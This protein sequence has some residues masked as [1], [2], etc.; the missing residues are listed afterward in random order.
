MKLFLAITLIGF[1]FSANAAPVNFNQRSI[2]PYGLVARWIFNEGSG[3]NAA[4]CSGYENNAWMTN[5]TAG[6]GANAWQ[7]GVIG[8]AINFSNHVPYCFL[9]AGT[10]ASLNLTNSMTISAWVNLRSYGGGSYGRIVDKSAGATIGYGFCVTSL[11]LAYFTDTAS[12]ANFKQGG[13]ALVY[14]QWYHV[15]ITI[16]GTNV[17]MYTNGIQCLSTTVT[18]ATP[19]PNSV[20]YIGDR[21]DLS[22]NFDGVIDDICLYNRPLSA[23]E[24]KQNYGGGYGA[25]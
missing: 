14:N 17:I 2:V 1:C 3:T 19:N 7:A 18:I 20:C 6:Y 5:Y 15:I 13:G 21:A 22:R 9:N 16:D 11:G 4:D 8:G 12:G 25:Q 24:V 10:N 23:S